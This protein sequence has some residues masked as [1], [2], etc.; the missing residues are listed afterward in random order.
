MGIVKELNIKNKTYYFFNDM[1][2]ITN[3]QS[4]LLTID[5]K[6]YKDFDIYYIGYIPIKKIGNY[7]NI[8]SVNPVYLI[9][10]W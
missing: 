3:F 7:E 1:I 6:P 10:Q 5:K 2:D 8:Q 4:N 9:I